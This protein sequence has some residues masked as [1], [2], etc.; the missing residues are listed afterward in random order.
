MMS[1][2]KIIRITTVPGSMSSLLQGQLNYI[3]KFYNVI[4][5][6]SP[7]KAVS[8]I[9]EKEGVFVYRVSMT[10]VISPLKDIKSLI[11][12]ILILRKEKPY[13]VH[14][15]T[16]KAGII[17]MLASWIVGVP[18]RLHTVAGLPLLV[19]KGRK[20]KVLNLVEKITYK[21]A[22]KVYP[23][24]KGLYDIIL[25]E[26]FTT[27]EKIKVIGNGSSNG[28]DTDF[29]NPS[30]YTSE[31]II[32]IK[33]SLCI[34]DDDHVFL[35]VGRIVGDKGIN[36]L[37]DAFIRLNVSNV[38]LLLVGPLESQLD[39]LKEIT[40]RRINDHPDV[41]SVGFQKDVRPFFAISDVL[42][43]P[44]YREGFPNVVM[45]AA[46]MQLNCI[47][48]DINGCNE[49]IENGIN[50]WVVPVMSSIAIYEKMCWCLNNRKESKAMGLGS[51]QIMLEK[52]ERKFVWSRVL[53]EYKSL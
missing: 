19:A 32:R 14:T 3:K 31:D 6:T 40:L 44:S 20:R 53:E 15:H 36:E 10:R 21:C 23:N 35:F 42:V 52:Y 4:G 51:R 18:H 38:K 17:G 45:Q 43:F 7:G 9:E 5:I 8:D 49:I 34:K 41:L 47:V 2:K 11:S 37:V 50:G 16:P 12:I 39:P 48:S 33:K 28:I 1:E 24:S 25:H 46:S 30:N 13:I 26:K 22:T 27:K 29:F